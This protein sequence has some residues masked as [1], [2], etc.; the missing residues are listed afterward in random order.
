MPRKKGPDPF[1]AVTIQRR[2][3]PRGVPAP[4]RLRRW[5]QAALAARAG[6]MTLRIVG[7]RESRAL[8]RRFRGKDKPTNVLSFPYGEPGGEGPHP[9]GG[10]AAGPP[11]S[12]KRE[13]DSGAAFGRGLILGDLVIC[14]PVVNREAR[15]QGK[16][17][18]AHW[19][20][21][22]VHGVLHLCG[23][24]HIRVRD[25]RVMEDRERAILAR[26]SFPDPYRPVS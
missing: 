13:R 9:T 15:A 5:A 1:S 8:N 7:E 18:A 3:P 20:H 10:S 19:A 23:F 17:P 6:E 4:G 21:M 25:A 14:A 22:V 2:V 16:A 26:L 11:L 24:D 12:R